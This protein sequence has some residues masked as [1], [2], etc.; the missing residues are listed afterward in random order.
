MSGLAENQRVAYE[1]YQQ[2]HALQD[3]P[4]GRRS[5]A[6]YVKG[7]EASR[8]WPKVNKGGPI[9]AHRPD[10]GPCWLWTAAPN[11]HG[12]GIFR[13][14]AKKNVRA[15]R[16]AY[17]NAVGCVPEGLDLDHL[18]RNRGCVNPAHLE[19]VTSTENMRR[20]P[21]GRRAWRKLITHCPQ[22]HEYTLENTRI[23]GGVRCCR[24]CTLTRQ[25][26]AYRAKRAGQCG[27]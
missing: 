22:G 27:R 11:E 1:R 25:R 20:A 5:R 14:A 16:W 7:D 3:A 8:F 18:C 2:A 12:Y 23:R 26:A 10:L 19:P 17:E 24:T 15:H 4:A 21:P 13:N 6:K 9:P